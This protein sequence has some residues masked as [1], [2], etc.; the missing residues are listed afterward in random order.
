MRTRFA[1]SLVAFVLLVCAGCDSGSS[2]PDTLAA[3]WQGTFTD[4]ATEYTLE[5]ALSS[6]RAAGLQATPIGGDGT[7]VIQPPDGDREGLSITVEGTFNAP[8]LSLSVSY[9]QSRP[10]QLNGTVNDALDRID[11]EL[12]GGGPGFDGVSVVLERQ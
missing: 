8:R 7:L 2:G 6:G 10:G 5:L 9:P 12:V 3:V 1:P 4:N 11:A